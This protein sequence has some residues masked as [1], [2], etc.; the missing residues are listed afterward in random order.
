MDTIQDNDIEK[1]KVMDR[2][3]E[4]SIERA[5]ANGLLFGDLVNNW[6]V[7]ALLDWTLKAD[8]VETFCNRLETLKKFTGGTTVEEYVARYG[9]NEVLEAHIAQH[10][11]LRVIHD[12][13]SFY[14]Q[15]TKKALLDLLEMPDGGEWHEIIHGLVRRMHYLTI[16]GLSTTCTDNLSYTREYPEYHGLNKVRDIATAPIKLEFKGNIYKV[17]Y[18]APPS[19]DLIGEADQYEVQARAMV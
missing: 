16:V 2:S 9:S 7:S 14:Y 5:D 12:A 18:G 8:D 11:E 1:T 13:A 19:L 6:N 15:G 4:R 3:L 17:I 10:P